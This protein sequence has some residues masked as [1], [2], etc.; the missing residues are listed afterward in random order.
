MFN[1]LYMAYKF[2]LLSLEGCT[3]KKQFEAENVLI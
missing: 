3:R 2:Y 1:I